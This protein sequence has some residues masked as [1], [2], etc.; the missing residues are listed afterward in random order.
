V[1]VASSGAGLVRSLDGSVVEEGTAVPI[2]LSLS[3]SRSPLSGAEVRAWPGGGLL[4]LPRSGV[5]TVTGAVRFPRRGRHRLGPASL[6]IT[7][8]FGLRCRT[9]ASESDEVLV[10][11]RVEPLRFV[12]VSG[13]GGAAGGGRI[14]GAGDALASEVDGLQPHHPGTP[15]SRIHWPAVARTTT[16]IERRLVADGEHAPLVVV[17]PREPSSVDALDQ[18]MRAAASLCV[19]L[20]RHGGCALLLPGDR[21]PVHLDPGLAGFA[22]VHARLAVLDP[23][24]GGPSMGWLTAMQTVLWVTAT[25]GRPTALEAVR[26][27]VRYLVSPHRQDRWPLQFSVAGCSGQRLERQAAPVELLKAASALP[28]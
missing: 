9:I 19:H 25:S 1:H 15:A 14:P 7:D 21:R 17:D 23:A 5:S 18:A 27:P 16:L 6:L 13:A 8:P 20:A 11:P 24:D 22:Q 3:H 2:T 12:G 10:L 4:E 26:A 28:A